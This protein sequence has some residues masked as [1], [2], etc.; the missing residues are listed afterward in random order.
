MIFGITFDTEGIKALGKHK[1]SVVVKY[2]LVGCRHEELHQERFSCESNHLGLPTI[3]TDVK[4]ITQHYPLGFNHLEVLVD[5]THLSIDDSKGIML[6]AFR[7]YLESAQKTLVCNISNAA[8]FVY[9]TQVHFTYG[10]VSTTTLP[11]LLGEGTVSQKLV[12]GNPSQTLI[13]Y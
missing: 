4:F 2:L 9:P 11:T 6:R 5:F 10:I 3:P 13:T 12:C 8:F 1:I 7:S